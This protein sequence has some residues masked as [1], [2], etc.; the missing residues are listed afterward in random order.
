MPDTGTLRGD[1]VAVIAGVTE[2]L[3]TLAGYSL[4]YMGAVGDDDTTATLRNAFWEERFARAR[5]IFARA[6]ARG[7][8]RD[9]RRADLVYEMLIGTLHFRILGQRRVLDDGI[10]E[11]LVDLVLDGVRD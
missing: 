4:A 6:V 8:L 9:T 7:E 5:E 3:R 2:F 10:A 11:R 1:L